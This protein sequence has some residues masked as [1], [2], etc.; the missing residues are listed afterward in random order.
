MSIPEQQNYEKILKEARMGENYLL[1]GPDVYWQ[2][3]FTEA[4]RKALRK[5]DVSLSILYGDEVKAAQ[6]NDE[7]D[8]LS[9]FADLKLIIIKNADAM[10]IKELKILSGYFSSPME[11]QTLVIQAEKVDIRTSHWKKMKESCH[12][13]Q[14]DKP[15]FTGQIKDWVQQELRAMG[16][17]MNPRALESFTTRVELDYA[18]AKNELDKLFLLVG[19]RK[20]ISEAEVE[21]SIG[22][23]R[24]GAQI[25]FFRALGT[26]K[27]DTCLNAVNLML[28]SEQEPLSIVFMIQRFFL[29]LWKIRIL[30]AKHISKAEIIQRHLMDLFLNQRQEYANMA[31][32]YSQAALET[33]FDVLLELDSQI[34]SISTD[35]RLLL[36]LALIKICQA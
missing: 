19:E 29:V 20:T 27:V 32:N 21:M 16:K 11:N 2:D 23:S 6:L 14:C 17:T 12:F 4:V 3:R 34:K 22:S 25:D 18:T 26:R 15:K 1:V 9:L 31:E 24:V 30:R 7:L 28:D 5:K 36:S 8:S 13:F 10:N 35:P 33:V